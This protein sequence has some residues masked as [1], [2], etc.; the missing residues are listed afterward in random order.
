MEVSTLRAEEVK[1]I[2]SRWEPFHRGASSGVGS[3]SGYGSS[4]G[5][6]D[7]PPCNLTN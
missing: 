6:Y 7:D 4:R 3:R 5:L 2:L 1:D